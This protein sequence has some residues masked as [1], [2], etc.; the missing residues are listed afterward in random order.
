MAGR[1][2]SG[3]RLTNAPAVIPSVEH[4]GRMRGFDRLDD[5]EPWTALPTL[6]KK[7]STPTE[8]AP[9]KDVSTLFESQGQADKAPEGLINMP[10]ASRS[11][12]KRSSWPC[13]EGRSS[14]P[15]RRAGYDHPQYGYGCPCARQGG[16]H[17]HSN[18]QTIGRCRY[19]R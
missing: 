12:R 13:R 2:R 4:S 11:R 3:Q 17:G 10:P 8:P 7:A 14:A 19:P 5:F 16:R 9:A 18:A 6:G 1:R 15:S